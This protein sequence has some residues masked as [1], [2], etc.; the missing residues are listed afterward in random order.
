MNSQNKLPTTYFPVAFLK[1]CL[2]SWSVTEAVLK[3]LPCCVKPM[4]WWI[5]VTKEGTELS[6]NLMW[7]V[8]SL[9]IFTEFCFTMEMGIRLCY[10][11]PVVFQPQDWLPIIITKSL[12]TLKRFKIGFFFKTLAFFL[13]P[14][15]L[16][17]SSAASSL[18]CFPIP[19]GLVRV[20]KSKAGLVESKK[21]TVLWSTVLAYCFL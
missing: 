8:L 9:D 1:I 4:F 14:S 5:L 17:L 19:W 3:S 12:K 6:F 7:L 18:R 15:L 11:K 21:S 16:C 13:N 20:V 2:N 10:W